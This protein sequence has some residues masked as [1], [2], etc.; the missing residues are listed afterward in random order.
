MQEGRSVRRHHSQSGWEGDVRLRYT[1]DP[2]KG[3]TIALWRRKLVKM[4]SFR[5]QLIGLSTE[6]NE[7]N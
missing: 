7:Q 5:Q 3:L 6:R 1:A 4:D 2:R